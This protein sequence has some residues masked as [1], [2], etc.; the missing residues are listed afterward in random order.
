MI[1]LI[2]VESYA[3]GVLTVITIM[4]AR[5]VYSAVKQEWR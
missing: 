5:H 2:A 3:L 1:M 4:V